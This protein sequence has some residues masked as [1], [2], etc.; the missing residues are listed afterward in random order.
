MT[1]DNL[2]KAFANLFSTPYLC[3]STKKIL[4][5]SQST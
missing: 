3:L 1:R 4:G 5:G 2:D